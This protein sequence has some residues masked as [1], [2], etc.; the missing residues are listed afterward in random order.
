MADV[1]GRGLAEQAEG[2][3]ERSRLQLERLNI[4]Q[5]R[6]A[7]KRLGVYSVSATKPKLV[8]EL[9]VVLG[10][11][12]WALRKALK[13]GPEAVAMWSSYLKQRPKSYKQLPET[14][15]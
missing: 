14:T 5:L 6:E 15:E 3:V 9:A 7:A 8:T 13:N 4:P 10:P 1:V 2:R 11:R 12:W